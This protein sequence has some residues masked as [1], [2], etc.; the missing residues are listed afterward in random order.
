MHDEISVVDESR[1]QLVEAI[2]RQCRHAGDENYD[3]FDDYQHGVAR[4]IGLYVFR[5][6]VEFDVQAVH[7]ARI[8][9]S[10]G[11]VKRRA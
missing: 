10:A 11:T 9:V 1:V 4:E 8:H 2:Y 7:L 3:G 6:P 5:Q